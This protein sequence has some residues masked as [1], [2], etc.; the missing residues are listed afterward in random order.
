M[1]SMKRPTQSF[2]F[3]SLPSEL[4]SMV[5]AQFVGLHAMDCDDD[6]RSVNI[7]CIQPLLQVRN[8][9]IQKAVLHMDLSALGDVLIN[10]NIWNGEVVLLGDGRSSMASSQFEHVMRTCRQMRIH[11]DASSVK[12]VIPRLTC[13]PVQRC[14][15]LHGSSLAH[16]VPS[17]ITC[18]KVQLPREV[19]NVNDEPCA[20]SVDPASHVQHLSIRA[21]NWTQLCNVRDLTSMPALSHAL[22]RLTIKLVRRRTWQDSDAE[23]QMLEAIRTGLPIDHPSRWAVDEHPT[24]PIT[25]VSQWTLLCYIQHYRPSHL[26]LIFSMYGDY[27]T[28]CNPHF[29]SRSGLYT[30]LRSLSVGSRSA[31]VTYWDMEIMTEHMSGLKSLTAWF[32]CAGADQTT[33]PVINVAPTLQELSLHV[34]GTA[35]V[36]PC[37]LS[38]GSPVESLETVELCSDT[39]LIL[40]L[41]SV[42]P[43]CRKLHICASVSSLMYDVRILDAEPVDAM[44]QLS[45]VRVTIVSDG[46]GNLRERV[47]LP[48][49]AT[50]PSVK[51]LH[52][53]Q[54]L[55]GYDRIRSDLPQPS[56]VRER[57]GRSK[58]IAAYVLPQVISG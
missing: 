46:A 30:H 12:T 39:G 20:V 6:Q 33:S 38:R 29:V 25:P 48:L 18:L 11:S 43:M 45:V 16:N 57:L 15:M 36:Y 54:G 10:V 44:K 2:A 58:F 14:S 50:L 53:Q 23:I 5:F 49:Y 4:M 13:A 9:A 8:A 52:V 22:G 7:D 35:I 42:A 41:S 1:S 47:Y 31:P 56:G 3:M 40:G 32:T 37:L 27:T 55:A 26:H 28:L 34:V 24:L 51:V 19:V 21:R 17:R